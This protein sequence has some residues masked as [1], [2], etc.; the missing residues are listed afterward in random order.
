MEKI[1]LNKIDKNASRIGLGTWAIGGDT[2]GPSDDEKAKIAIHSA[3]KEHDVNFIDTAP[4][5]GNGHSESIVGEVIDQ[6]DRD[7][8]IIATKA[9]LAVKDGS[10][11]R[12]ATR[13]KLNRDL[14]DSLDRLQ[15]D[16]IDILFVHWPDP[17]ISLEETAEAMNELLDRGLIGSIGVSNFTL[18][19]L[20]AFRKSAPV[21]FIQP[22]Y[23]LF[24]REFESE[25]YDFCVNHEIQITT[26]GALCRGMLTG[27][28]R[29]ETEFQG[30]DLR[31]VDPKFNP[32]RYEQYLAAVDALG[33]FAHENYDKNIVELSVRYILDKG[34]DVA[35]WGARKPEQLNQ[36][37]GLWN[38]QLEPEAIDK[39]EE[40]IAQHLQ[41]PLNSPYFMA[42]PDRNQ[43]V[44]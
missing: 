31:N 15:T 32:P 34:M 10:P 7:Q 41:E 40:I 12:M 22:P 19:Q 9:G 21:H 44:V 37:E 27:K 30:G 33:K 38:W 14:E 28:M 36:V 25:L 43:I 2:W 18:E 5:Y 29:E 39:V 26:Y 13:D 20:M 4:V 35:L 6:H 17:L 11:Y 42:P 24:E 8:L 23:N 3:I 16:L 1:K